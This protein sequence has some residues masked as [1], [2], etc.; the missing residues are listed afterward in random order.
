MDSITTRHGRSASTVSSVLPNSEAPSTRRGS[1]STI[2]A[3]RMSIA[4]STIR[5]PAWP[6]RI[7]STWPETRRPP[8]TRACSITDWAA[9][10]A[11][12]HRRVDRQRVRHGHERDDVHAAPL[13]GRELGRGRH[14]VLVV[15]VGDRHQHGV[16]LR[17]VVDDGL[18]DRD[19]V[20]GGQVEPVAAAEGGVDERPERQ[21]ADAE[22]GHRE[23]QRRDHDERDRREGAAGDR[24]QRRVVVRRSGG[25]PARGRSAG[26]PAACA[27]AGSRPRAR[28]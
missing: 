21:P 3:A 22:R 1:A 15:A 4:S 9:A 11:S 26:S 8:W 28:S 24:E 6:G 25:C 12:R 18:R 20:G 23:V 14:H 17:L 19:L 13:A 16:V 5:R 10:S 27:A 2:A 7:R